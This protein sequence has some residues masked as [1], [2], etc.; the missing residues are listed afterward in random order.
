MGCIY[1]LT[2]VWSYQVAV[3]VVETTT[4]KRFDDK[5]SA[6]KCKYSTSIW[7]H[8]CLSWNCWILSVWCPASLC[9]RWVCAATIYKTSLPPCVFSIAS[10]KHSRQKWKQREEK[11]HVTSSNKIWL[12]KGRWGEEQSF[13]S[14]NLLLF[15]TYDSCVLFGGEL[16]FFPVLCTFE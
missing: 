12:P 1:S 2:Y 16:K 13:A 8:L 14:Y 5:G 6:G 15:C 7:F 9:G 4:S 10:F 3:H 11:K